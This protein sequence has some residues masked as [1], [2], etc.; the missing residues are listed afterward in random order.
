MKWYVQ[1]PPPPGFY[2]RNLPGTLP[3]KNPNPYQ[4][5]PDPF[6]K[7]SHFLPPHLL[8]NAPPT[9]SQILPENPPTLRKRP[10]KAPILTN[11]TQS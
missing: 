3:K 10:E 11:K 1:S 9:S 8:T 7:T 4:I 2:I 5:S 6:P